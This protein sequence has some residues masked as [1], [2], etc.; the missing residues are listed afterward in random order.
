MALGAG[1]TTVM[2]MVT[3]YAIIANGGKEDEAVADRPHPGPLRQDGLQARRRSAARAA[4]PPTGQNQP[5]PQIIDNSEQVLD[6]MTAYQ[7]TSM[8]EGVIKRGTAGDHCPTSATRSPARPA[9]P[10]TRRMPGSSASRRTSWSASS[11]AT[12][13]RARWARARQ[14]AG[15]LRRSSR[16]SCQV[17]LRDKPKVDFRVPEG[18][19]LIAIDRK[20][21]M[22]ASARAAR[23]DHR[24]LQARHRA[25]RQLLGDWLR[26]GGGLG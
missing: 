13:S 9:R 26:Y 20:T 5:E 17:A 22:R 19:K 16:S 24:G 4:S 18:M 7:I 11:S 1:E 23:R 21:G 3:A 12:T 8:M 2:R 14:A 10:T 15:S 25:G 6:P